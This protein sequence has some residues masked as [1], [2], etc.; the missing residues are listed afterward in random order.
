MILSDIATPKLLEE[1]NINTP[2]ID[3]GYGNQN[4]PSTSPVLL[5]PPVMGGDPSKV[6]SQPPIRTT[7]APQQQVQTAGIN[8]SSVKQVFTN[9]PIIV[10]TGAAL[11]LAGIGY[12]VLK[13]K[14]Q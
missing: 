14:K 10:Y 6:N 13:I 4:I 1:I 5:P 12:S 7:S 11:L 8:L 9:Q 2:K 3:R